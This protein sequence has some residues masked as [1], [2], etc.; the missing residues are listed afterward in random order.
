MNFS[1]LTTGLCSECLYLL[2]KED[3]PL[4]KEIPQTVDFMKTIEHLQALPDEDID[5]NV[6]CDSCGLVGINKIAGK[7]ELEFEDV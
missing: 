6:S 1:D 7:I 3:S 5:F 2:Y 4:Y